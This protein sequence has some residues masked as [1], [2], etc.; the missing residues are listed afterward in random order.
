MVTF[1]ILWYK[2]LKGNFQYLISVSLSNRQHQLQHQHLNQHRHLHPYRSRQHPTW[3]GWTWWIQK[4]YPPAEEPEYNTRWPVKHGRVFLV[5]RKTCTVA[6]TVK[7]T[8]T[9]K[10]RPCLSG[11]VV[12]I[13]QLFTEEKVND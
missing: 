10:T 3:R 6:Y 12:D 2:H 8:F 4:G 1:I 5:P 13:I 7:V 9:R 11:R